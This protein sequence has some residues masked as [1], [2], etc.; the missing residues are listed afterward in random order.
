MKVAITGHTQGIGLAIANH[1]STHDI[2]G[3]SR[4]TGYDINQ[5][6]DRTRILSQITNCDMFVNNAY[7]DRDNSQL[8]LLIAVHE[9]WRDTNRTIVN[10]SSRYAMSKNG[11][12]RE[13]KYLQD[14]Y[15]ARNEYTLPYIINL[16]PGLVNTSRV[17]H[18]QG[19]RLTV[20][21]VV[22]MLS[23]VLTSEFKIHTVTFGK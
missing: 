17:A 3:F 15:C 21:Q 11:V 7:G 2:L 8:L 19:P 14:L 18:I 5:A 20:D 10:I 9:L 23:T 16:K 12:Y 22:G 6:A 13:N 1:F 4:A